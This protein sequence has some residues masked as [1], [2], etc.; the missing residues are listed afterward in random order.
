MPVAVIVL[1]LG[2]QLCKWA[3]YERWRRHLAFEFFTESKIVKNALDNK[4]NYFDF[5][6]EKMPST[7][8]KPHS[9]QNLEMRQVETEPA[10]SYQC[11]QT[12]RCII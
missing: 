5:K 1:N 4:S 3:S 9:D 7:G 11:D 10:S 8:V 12:R 6:S 2:E